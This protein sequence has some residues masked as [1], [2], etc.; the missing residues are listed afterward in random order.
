MSLYKVLNYAKQVLLLRI[1][2]LAV[3]TPIITVHPTSV[4]TPVYV[5]VTFI[6]TAKSSETVTIVWRKYT[7]ILPPVARVMLM[8]SEVN[9]EVTS[10]LKIPRIVGYYAGDYYC[11]A[12]NKFGNVVSN[13]ASLRI[14]GGYMYK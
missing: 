3:T 9:D 10:I 1:Y 4:T 5:T 7:S 2:D 6:C 14:N 8:E 11:I 13:Y 12:Y